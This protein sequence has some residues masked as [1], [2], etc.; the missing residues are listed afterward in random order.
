MHG[1]RGN[2]MLCKWKRKKRGCHGQ[3]SRKDGREGGWLNTL[4]RRRMYDEKMWICSFSWWPSFLFRTVRPTIPLTHLFLSYVLTSAV[5]F[6]I[7]LPPS[8]YFSFFFSLCHPYTPLAPGKK[9]VRNGRTELILRARKAKGGP[10]SLELHG[11]LAITPAKR[12][13]SRQSFCERLLNIRTRVVGIPLHDSVA[14]S[15]YRRG[16]F[17]LTD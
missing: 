15:A 5:L 8:P 9:F 12:G 11:A 6:L 14:M 13:S 16:T 17:M 3:P 4:P 10:P 1:R 7:Y 2:Y